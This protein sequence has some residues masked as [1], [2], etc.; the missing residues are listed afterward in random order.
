L[1]KDHPA[2][3]DHS[4]DYLF[5]HEP[6]NYL[7][8]TFSPTDPNKDKGVARAL[9]S[10]NFKVI[11]HLDVL[12]TA[13]E[14]IKE[15][16]TRV[17]IESCDLTDKRMYVRFI[18]P[19]IKAEAPKL[20]QNYKAPK[21]KGNPAEPNAVVAGFILSN[22]ETGHG[23]F[24]I[25]PRLVVL[26]CNNGM[27]RMQ[28]SLAKTHLGAKLDDGVIDWSQATIVKNLELIQ[29]QVKDAVK[30]FANPDY[31]ARTIREIESMGTELLKHPVDAVN[32]VCSSLKLSDERTQSILDYFVKAGDTSRFGITQA[33]TAYAQDENPDDRH[34]L[35]VD[36]MNILPKIAALDFVGESK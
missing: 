12:V 31:L 30:A 5:K 36:A 26:V 34:E 7:V 16:G 23:R 4:V 8:R 27:T 28:D 3:L 29:L 1:K 33:M 10:D 15:S 9:L 14:A 6:K 21:G 24:I 20:L 11:D 22:S 19:D 32:N 2:L 35:E 25:A 13:L 17:E 18:A